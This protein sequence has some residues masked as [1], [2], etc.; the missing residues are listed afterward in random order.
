M[1][2]IFIFL[3][4]VFICNFVIAQTINGFENFRVGTHYLFTSL[5]NKYEYYTSD[6]VNIIVRKDVNFED[7]FVRNIHQVTSDTIYF[8]LNRSSYDV[9]VPESRVK[10]TVINK[11]ASDS[12]FR[13]DFLNQIIHIRYWRSKN[14]LYCLY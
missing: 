10:I 12:Q 1:K 2:K 4:L 8:N 9:Y 7:A 11:T 5:D 3:V 14:L 13:Q 6:T